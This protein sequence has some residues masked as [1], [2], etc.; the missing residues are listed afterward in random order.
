[1][2]NGM[3][4]FKPYLWLGGEERACASL[5]TTIAVGAR[6]QRAAAAQSAPC[7]ALRRDK[8]VLTLRL[9]SC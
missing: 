6:C 9:T 3:A 8:G 5:P 2:E 4:T 7:L 1:M